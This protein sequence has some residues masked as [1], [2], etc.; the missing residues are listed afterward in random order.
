[1]RAYS[2]DL[3]ARIVRAV[4]KGMSKAAAARRYEVGLST[5]KR[6][7][8]LGAGGSLVPKLSPGRPRTLDAAGEVALAEHRRLWREAEGSAVSRSTRGPRLSA[9]VPAALLARLQPD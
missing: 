1:M 6:Y 2:T 4:E 3:R 8:R 9:P 7:A 5:V